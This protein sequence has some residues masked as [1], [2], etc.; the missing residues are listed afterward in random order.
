MKAVSGFCA[1]WYPHVLVIYGC[2]L[3][4]STLF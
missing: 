4:L 3:L 2:V 1:R